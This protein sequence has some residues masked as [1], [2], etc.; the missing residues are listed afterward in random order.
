MDMYQTDRL[1]ELFMLIYEESHL[2]I[3]NIRGIWAKFVQL[4]LGVNF[5][6]MEEMA[7]LDIAKQQK[8]KALWLTSYSDIA[9]S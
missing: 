4:I 9:T 3:R 2:I 7:A 1:S 8:T 6:I 5:N